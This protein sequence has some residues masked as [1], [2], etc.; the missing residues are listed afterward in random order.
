MPDFERL[1]MAF[2]ARPL[3][4]LLREFA[5]RL[6]SM[7]ADSRG[8]FQLEAE[9]LD[10]AMMPGGNDVA[11]QFAGFIRTASGDFVALWWH[12]VSTT[13]DDAPVVF[14]PHDDA[15]WVLAPNLLSFLA[16]VV[17][18]TYD[19]LPCD[20]HPTE[21]EETDEAED[22]ANDVMQEQL[23][24]WLA[25]HCP[26]PRP[27]KKALALW[28]K[29]LDA[30]IDQTIKAAETASAQNSLYREIAELLKP[31]WMKLQSMNH[32]FAPDSSLMREITK[33]TEYH[34]EYAELDLAGTL[35]QMAGQNM[36]MPT[37][38]LLEIYCAGRLFECNVRR[39]G[40][41]DPIPEA[42]ALRPLIEQMRAADLA[43]Y[44]ERGAWFS[45][46]LTL[47]QQGEC[48]WKK[49]WRS[50]PLFERQP[51]AKV[52]AALEAELTQHPRSTFWQL[53]D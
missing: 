44:P 36:Q 51:P 49:H 26:P 18:Q 6:N 43:Q 42:A 9:Y 33:L 8:A 38:Q 24:A 46:W 14:F 48:E 21:G 35:A 15:P 40:R 13:A 27:T 12:D 30:L 29:R 20:L 31:Y 34:P 5:E 2:G 25:T 3:P 45:A 1:A 16:C 22:A 23:A 53:S 52:R 28:Q 37:M 10:D 17:D 39:E 19:G 50:R 11:E 7:P 32:L 4:V 41:A 47:G